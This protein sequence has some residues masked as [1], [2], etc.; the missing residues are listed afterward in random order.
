M[1]IAL[2]RARAGDGELLFDWVNQPDVLSQK[3]LTRKA[4]ARPDHDKWFTARLADPETLLWIIESDQKAIGQ[5]RLMKQAD[6]YEVDIYVVLAQRR[7]GV[8]QRALTLG[9]EV[10]FRERGGA[11]VVRAMVKPDNKG[12]QKLFARAGFALAEQHAD[13]LVY[14]LSTS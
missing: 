9:I 12:S 13:H 1:T 6:A 11:Q 3:L 14:D 10:L 8:A 4:I 7:S 5:L 2:R